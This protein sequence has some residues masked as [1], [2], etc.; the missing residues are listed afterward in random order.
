MNDRCGGDR[1]CCTNTWTTLGKHARSVAF[2]IWPHNR[3]HALFQEHRL[4]RFRPGSLRGSVRGS[5][6]SLVEIAVCA[7]PASY[8]SRCSGFTDIPAHNGTRGYGNTNSLFSDS[9]DNNHVSVWVFEG[10]RSIEILTAGGISDI[11]SGSEDP[12]LHKRLTRYWKMPDA[13][14]QS[15]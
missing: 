10:S 13:I 12:T 5:W 4:H 1:V 6:G 15:L 2:L 7:I 11:S 8:A 9:R 3:R 14:V